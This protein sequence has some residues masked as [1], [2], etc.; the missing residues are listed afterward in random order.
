[1]MKE[2]PSKV[3][4]FGFW[5]IVKKSHYAVSTDKTL[6]ISSTPETCSLG[7]FW[8]L[9]FSHVYFDTFLMGS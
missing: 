1:M 5:V 6:I 4:K 9:P 7:Y 3:K 2:K 8:P